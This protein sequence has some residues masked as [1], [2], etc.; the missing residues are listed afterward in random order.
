VN[1]ST[2]LTFSLGVFLKDLLEPRF[3]QIADEV[4]LDYRAMPFTR[5]I[6]EMF[7]GDRY[8]ALENTFR[9]YLTGDLYHEY[10]LG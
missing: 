4:H 1:T 9:D 10:S 2:S 3:R 7:Y 5:D 6:Y 8:V